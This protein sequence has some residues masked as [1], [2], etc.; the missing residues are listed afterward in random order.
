M[1][2]AREGE[3][4]RRWVA[5]LPSTVAELLE[6]WR[7]RLD[8]APLYGMCAVVLRVRTEEGRG[9]LKVGWVDDETRA[10][11]LGLRAWAG[12]G[13]VALLRSEE[14]VGAMLL[15]RLDERRTLLDVPIDEAL[16]IAA[17]ILAELRVPAVEGLNNAGDTAARWGKEFLDDWKRLD[18]PCSEEMLSRAVELCEELATC[19]VE[20]STLHGDFHYANILGR[21]ERAWA[22]IDP[23]PLAGDPAYE[24]VPLLRNRW[25]EIRGDD[26]TGAAVRRRVLRFAELASLD[27]DTTYKWCLVRT[28]DDAMWF[29]EHGYPDRAEIAWDIARSMMTGP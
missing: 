10:E 29:Q 24:V 2:I 7:L 20:P 22:A 16:D 13:A 6:A 17:V 26:P 5:Q 3:P 1:M 4:A 14:R 9:A 19:A 8:G 27:P 28:V 25:A 15:E 12:R 11:P 21:G 18:R 23:K